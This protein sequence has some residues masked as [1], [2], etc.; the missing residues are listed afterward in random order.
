MDKM[1]TKKKILLG[2]LLAA[3]IGISFETVYFIVGDLVITGMIKDISLISFFAYIGIVGVTA[4]IVMI[5]RN[6]KKKNMISA[7][8]TLTA[9]LAALWLHMECL[10]HDSVVYYRLHGE[11]M[12][13][14][15]DLGYFFFIAYIGSI[16]LI[17]VPAAIIMLF[18]PKKNSGEKPHE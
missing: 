11:F 4:F 7:L 16:Y 8:Q 6:H 5:I 18:L 9:V 3:I 17:L 15:D 12:P 10:R 1:V 2:F 14:Y 13:V